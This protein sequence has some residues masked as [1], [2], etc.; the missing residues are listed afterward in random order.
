MK[1]LGC[2]AAQHYNS[3]CDAQVVPQ[4]RPRDEPQQVEHL[5]AEVNPEL[6]LCYTR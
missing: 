5:D 2:F 3:H 6:M 4:V 1:Q